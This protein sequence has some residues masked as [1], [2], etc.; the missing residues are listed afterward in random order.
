MSIVYI[1]YPSMQRKDFNT[2]EGIP[3]L[4]SYID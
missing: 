1:N 3:V 2:D 4:I